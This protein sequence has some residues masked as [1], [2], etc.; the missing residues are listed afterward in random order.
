MRGHRAV[1]DAATR[2][3][4]QLGAEIVEIA[5]GTAPFAGI[6]SPH[7]EAGALGVFAAVTSGD[8]DC[9]TAFYSQRRTPP[10]VLVSPL[11]G[12]PL[13]QLLARAGYHPAEIQ[14]VLV[15][16]LVPGEFERNP[17]V[18]EI[19]DPWIWARASASG[20]LE[21]QAGY[22]DTVVAA[23]VAA[24]A[25]VQALAVERDGAIVA[26][27]AMEVHGDCLSLFAASTLPAQR[28]AGYQAALIRDRLARGA[29]A[30]AR[31]AQASAAVAS[32]SER[33]F[34]RLGFEVLY[35]RTVWERPLP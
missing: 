1:V 24:A 33:N 23:V 15:R 16:A 8:V 10:R 14:N 9:L 7:S 32:V 3:A 19:A 35:T 30:G 29:D 20:F 22:D 13:P 11:A 17:R 5:G 4:P 6:G 21:G 18:V 28:G 2:I 25:N 12:V 31:F 34:R 26:T 27:A